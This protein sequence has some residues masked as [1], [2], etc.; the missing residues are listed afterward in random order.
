MPSGVSRW[1]WWVHFV[2]IAGYFLPGA[3]QGVYFARNRPMLTSSTQGLLIVCTFN[4]ATFA[5][6][7]F[8][9]WL[10]SR[11]SP[12]ELF[13]PWRPG[14]WVL[15]LGIAYSIA[16]RVALAVAGFVVILVLLV[17]QL[18]NV[19]SLQELVLQNRPKIEQV[20][21]VSALQMNRA[22]YWLALT[23]VS[24]VAAGLRE[25]LWRAGT[26]AGMRALWPRTFQSRMGERTAIVLIAI[27]FGA[28]HLPMGIL[29]A[30]AAGVLG[31]FLGII[32]IVHRSIWPAVIA[33]GFFDA[34]SFV[35]MPFALHKLQQLR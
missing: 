13:L 29:A 15:P 20:I 17:T 10:A 1:R 30:A 31:L 18:V 4:L 24:F 2:L 23:L 3:L 26:L 21:S 12:E 22:Y 11:A 35:L 19:E 25:E 8:L 28:A 16:I 6:V 5:V 33:H 7:F 27:A 9:G 14:W 32:L 34:T